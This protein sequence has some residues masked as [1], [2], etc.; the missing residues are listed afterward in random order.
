VLGREHP[1]TLDAMRD[2][3]VSHLAAGDPDDA[4]ELLEPALTLARTVLGPKHPKTLSKTQDLA[5]VYFDIGRQDDALD[6]LREALALSREVNGPEHPETLAAMR[7]LAGACSAAGRSSETL[8]LREELL[9]LCMKAFGPQDPRTIGV[10]ADLAES[11]LNAGR[12][13]D[14]IPLLV[15]L[16][17]LEPPHTWGALT[18]A[19]L[20]L[21]SGNVADYEAVRDR[22][23][24][25]A[26]D[27]AAVLTG[28]RIA[29]L[30]SLRDHTIPAEARK[31][32][33][34]ARRAVEQG[35]D[36][37]LLASFQVSLGMAEYRA[38]LPEAVATLEAAEQSAHHHEPLDRARIE[39][40]A[41]FYRA[42]SLFRQGR[43][44]EARSL[45][46]ATETTMKPW[47]DPAHAPWVD[48][49]NVNDLILWLAC[50]E[51]KELLGPTTVG[52]PRIQ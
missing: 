4:L 46:L 47:S 1:G 19:A 37:L 48:A 33:T 49:M 29:R 14:A 45:F 39:G 51:A 8:D 20:Q 5:R 38:G 6:L 16:S 21:W 34:L 42:M 22:L 18:L 36:E 52:S 26:I 50:R 31:A 7:N 2:L 30:A 43:P 17:H 24:S 28:E 32:L 27:N 11:Y 41:R 15:G 44:D 12:T 35:G 9:P 10:T 40:T 25:W 3:A 13:A 23:L